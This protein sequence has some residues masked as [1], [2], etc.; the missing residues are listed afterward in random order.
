MDIKLI[1]AFIASPSGLELERQV[2]HEVAQ[3]VNSSVAC[4]LGGRLEL[5]GWEETLSGN[6]RPQALINAD[7]ETCDLFIG[8]IW[9]KWGSRPSK[10]GPYSSGFEEEFELSRLR[11]SNTGY[12]LMTVLFKDVDSLQLQDPGAEFKK[13]LEFRDRLISEKEFLYD[14][15]TTPDD[16]GVKVR[17]FLTRH[18]ISLLKPKIGSS[19]SYHS[20]AQSAT[21]PVDSKATA[22][23]LDLVTSDTSE[24]IFLSS[25]VSTMNNQQ[26]L[27][28]EDIARIRLIGSAFSG[29]ENDKSIIGAHDANLL[30]TNRT[31]YNLS[32]REQ[33]ELIECGLANLDNENVPIWTWLSQALAE[34]TKLLEIVSVIGEEKPRIG[35]LQALRLI[36]S[37]VEDFELLG[38]RTVSIWLSE[39]TPSAVRIAALRFLRDRGTEQ[40]LKAIGDEIARADKDTLAAALEAA[41]AI[42][43]RAG[44]IEAA[45]FVLGSSFESIGAGILE[46]ALLG[47]A[48]LA[49]ETLRSG[50][51]HRAAAVRARTIEVLSVRH[52]LDLDTLD[53]A[54]E[55]DAPIV[56]LAGLQAL[57]RLGQALSLDE[58]HSILVRPKRSSG[59]L[60]ALPSPDYEGEK[61]FQKYISERLM[62]SS[63]ES[64]VALLGSPKYK[65]DAYFALSKKKF[66]TFGEDLR[67]N[68]EGNFEGYFQEHWPDGIKV[69]PSSNSLLFIGIRDPAEAKRKELVDQALDI[70]V[71]QRN[72]NDLFL[73]RRV[74]DRKLVT[75]SAAVA[76]YLGLFG[77]FEDAQRLGRVSPY[78]GRGLFQSNVEISFSE[79]AKSILKIVKYDLN[80]LIN[81][82]IPDKLF[83]KIIELASFATFE[84]LTDSAILK[85]LLTDKDN[86]RRA[87]SRKIPAALE[88]R[89]VSRLMEAYRA[90]PEGR[91]YI[92]FHWLDLG[93]SFSRAIARRVVSAKD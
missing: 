75:P 55:D 89:R 5:I 56:R 82:D 60:F 13:V 40:Q 11:F 26:T 58:A 70:V 34:N 37:S 9:T 10:L 74:L 69:L 73:V 76:T 93:L 14:T 83:G 33:R 24:S 67:N 7:M 63:K 39:T 12:P 42:W 19:L 30:Y 68:L 88:R 80:I 62:Q 41:L 61:L 79:C 8:A 35:A 36:G 44:E 59:L 16:F 49:T 18:T 71:S 78:S 6:G 91:Y 72:L 86:Q 64:L 50:L 85:L 65:H 2:A 51:D 32:T 31:K 21:I 84:R 66:R 87:V 17:T 43:G 20:G 52:S 15:F 4:E 90:D 22:T 29:L 81:L 92:V 38:D 57:E 1:R 46:V 28:A 3:Q 53:R 25:V 27:E 23:I 45:K 47:L 77:K 54:K 48:K